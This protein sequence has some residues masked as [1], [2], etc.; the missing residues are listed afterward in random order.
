[1]SD[2]AL[3]GMRVGIESTLRAAGRKNPRG[4]SVRTPDGALIKLE[5]LV[6]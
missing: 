4:T 1:M 5:W 3:R 6:R 2:F